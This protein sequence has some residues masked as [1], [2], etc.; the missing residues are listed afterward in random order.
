[1][2]PRQIKGS[3]VAIYI[4]GEAV[5]AFSTLFTADRFGRKRSMQLLGVVALIGTVL[6]TSC[7][8]IGMLLA[9]RVIT[10]M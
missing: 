9:G 6:Q 1:L 2:L 4:A 5:G 3:I 10:G 7:I 8:S